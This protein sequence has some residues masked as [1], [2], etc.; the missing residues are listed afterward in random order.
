M[1]EHSSHR[2]KALRRRTHFLATAAAVGGAGMVLAAPGAALLANPGQAHAAP[3]EQL[4]GCAFGTVPVGD[5]DAASQSTPFV[6]GLGLQS[7]TLAP[8]FGT[9]LDA[10]DPFL[11]LAGG[12]PILNIFIGNGADGTQFSPNGTNGGLLI[13]S[14]GDGYSPNTVGTAGGNGGNAGFFIGHGG[15]GG[16]GGNGDATHAGGDGGSGGN[17]AMFIGNGGSGGNGGLG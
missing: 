11:D 16:T 10:A 13:G 17:G 3:L 14:G 15:A 8:S 1:L 7:A 4:F 9:G 6:I 5:C 12:I 2:G